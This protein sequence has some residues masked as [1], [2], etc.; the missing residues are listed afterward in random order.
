MNKF[1]FDV[2][3]KN[4]ILIAPQRLARPEDQNL[5]TNFVCPFCIENKHLTPPET[6]SL[7][8]IRVIPNKYPLTDIHEVV[9]NTQNCN[10]QFEELSE[11][12]VFNIFLVY[13][14]RFNTHKNKGQVLIFLNK[15]QLSGASIKHSHSQIVVIPNNFQLD[16][17]K[18]E[19]VENIIQKTENFSVYVPE[20]SK[21]PYELWISPDKDN[22]TFGD[23]DDENLRELS[24]LTLKYINKLKLINIERKIS[25]S[26]DY[27]FYIYP[28]DNWYLRIIPRFFVPGGFEIGSGIFV[29]VVDS[30][31][32]Q[33]ELQ[34]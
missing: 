32:V 16:T 19:P 28:F 15:G 1:V 25:L 31:I 4:T 9:I 33:K 7:N 21:Y 18:K 2:T 26:F 30:K 27:N 11:D 3:K 23:I 5:E 8:N 29:N 24:K 14:N 12:E 10:K 34:K 17:Q 22:N 6:F 13:K 20:F